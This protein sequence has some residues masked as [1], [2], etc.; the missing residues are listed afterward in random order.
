VPVASK[1]PLLCCSYF[2]MGVLSGEGGRVGRTTHAF[3]TMAC[4][5]DAA[6]AGQGAAIASNRVALG[7]RVRAIMDNRPIGLFAEH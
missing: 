4:D 2:M 3:E 1:E 6:S 7:R 5:P